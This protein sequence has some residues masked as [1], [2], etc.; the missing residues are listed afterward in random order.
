LR[1]EGFLNSNFYANKASGIIKPATSSAFISYSI[2]P[3]NNIEL[4]GE[5]YTAY[6]D[7]NAPDISSKKV[8]H[9]G[10]EIFANV[11]VLPPLGEWTSIVCPF[12]GIGYQTSSLK[13][14]QQDYSSATGG[15]IAK[16]G[17]RLYVLSRYVLRV[18]YKQTLPVG[19]EKLFRSLEFGFGL[20][21]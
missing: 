18:E 15:L 17:I 16:G 2:F 19:S 3:L 13:A 1:R 14:V 7:F 8:S 4:E 10:L 20:T 21:M 9:K 5:Y 6:Y 12:V 11:Y